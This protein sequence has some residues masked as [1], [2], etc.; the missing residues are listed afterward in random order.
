MRLS[1]IELWDFKIPFRDGP[2]KM[3]HVVQ[4]T[5]FGQVLC[6]HTDDGVC[7]LG[8]I[9][10]APALQPKERLALYSETATLLA[11]LAGQSETTLRGLIDQL[12]KKDASWNGI[13]F[14]LETAYYDLLARHTGVDFAEVLGGALDTSIEDYFSISEEQPDH[15]RQ[16]ILMAG[17]QRKVI[18][19][20]VGVYSLAHELGLIRT[21]LDL[22]HESQTL[23]VDAN[24]GWSLAQATEAIG[25]IQDPRLIWEE[26]CVS[27][28]ENRYL[29]EN[30]DTQ[31]LLDGET[32]RDFD[33]AKRAVN[34]GTAFG[35]CVKPAL[36]GGLSTARQIR[37]L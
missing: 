20:K 9:V 21:A 37:D 11:E 14:G 7:G 32:S 34:D 4:E 23:L 29:L 13:I 17:A 16:R 24:G 5:T 3:S 19:I 15:V 26:P 6:L 28:E 8:E 2:Y 1:K 12:Q 25:E 30:F 31:I 33:T 36:I 10:P 22:M 35:M 18:Q 27:Y